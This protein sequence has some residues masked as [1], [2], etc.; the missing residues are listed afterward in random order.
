VETVIEQHAEPAPQS[1]ID[2]AK[3]K[4]VEMGNAEV[5]GSPAAEKPEPRWK[6]YQ[7]GAKERLEKEETKAELATLVSTIIVLLLAM[8]PAPDSVKPNQ[9][10]TDG[11]SEHTCSIIV[12]HIDLSGK[13]TGDVLDVIGLLAVIGSWLTRVGPELRAINEQNEKTKVVGGVPTKALKSGKTMPV[14]EVRSKTPIEELSPAT[15]SY[16]DELA[17]EEHGSTD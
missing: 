5:S 4:L 10:E 9:A 7:K 16:L 15:K 13:I 6:R 14:Q 2:R 17:K 12:R 1:F 3:S 11:F 8:W